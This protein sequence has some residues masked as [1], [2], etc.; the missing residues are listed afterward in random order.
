MPVTKLSSSTRCYLGAAGSAATIVTRCAETRFCAAPV[1]PSAT[2]QR[3]SFGQR[4]AISL[5]IEGDDGVM[6]GCVGGFSIGESHVGE[7]IGLKVMPD[8][9]DVIEFGR[10][11][12]Q[13]FDGEPMS[14]GFKRRLRGLLTWIGP[15]SSAMTG[16]AML[17]APRFRTSNEF[18]K[19]ISKHSL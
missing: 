5:G 7:V 1:A 6:D 8:R 11:F 3:F 14:T 2:K 16:L 17:S 13:P 18:F 15:L 10:I 4:I 19:C 9:L 12:W